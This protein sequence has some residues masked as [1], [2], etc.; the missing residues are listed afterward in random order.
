MSVISDSGVSAE[1]KPALDKINAAFEQFKIENNKKLEDVK[2][3]SA[4]ALQALKVDAINAEIGKL[5]RE[6]DTLNAKAAAMQLGGSNGP[7]LKDPE[8]TK[9]FRAHFRKGDVQAN[10]QASLSKGADDQ[11]GYL[12]PVEW[13]RTIT[14]RL[15]Q[16]S[17]MRQLATVQTCS[18]AGFTKLYNMGGTTSGWVGEADPRPQ[19]SNA[20]FQPLTFGW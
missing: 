17:P 8:Y 19:T 4:D 14:D 5:Q 20:R 2:K 3:G 18:G 7:S 6:I 12:A 13:D 15:V 10:Y 11:G 1:L 9:A 16:I